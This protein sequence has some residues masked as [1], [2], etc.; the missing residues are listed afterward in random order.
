[1]LNALIRPAPLRRLALG[2]VV[3]DIGSGVGD[4]SNFLN[5]LES[6]LHDAET[7]LQKVNNAV[8][9]GAAGAQAGY[10]APTDLKPYL[11][12]GGVL[13]AVL[14]LGGRR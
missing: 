5:N 4:V 3:S 12:G 6:R 7:E 9:G 13:L 10:N 2:D 1:M 14:L 8:R 11:I